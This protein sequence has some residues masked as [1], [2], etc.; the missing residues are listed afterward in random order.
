MQDAALPSAFRRLAGSNL[1]AQLAE[2][3]ALAAVPLAAVL[4]LG[5]EVGSTG[6]LA[7]AQTL[8]FLLLAIPFGLLA[9]RTDRR[10]LMAAAEWVRAAAL[11]AIP[12]AAAGGWLTLPLLGLLGCVAAVGTV[13]F[14]VT[15]PA[16]VPAL[17]PR[18]ALAAANG[19]LELARSLAYAGGPAVAGGLA[20]VAGAP[21]AFAAA[22][23]LSAM[24]ALLLAGLPEPAR[25][26]P[27]PARRPLAEVREGA[28]F[29][30]RH[31]WLRPIVA[32]AIVWNLAWFVL[33][34][35]FVPHAAATLGLDAAGIGLTLAAYGVGMV[36]GAVLAPPVVRALPIGRMIA[37]GPFVSVAAAAAMAAS[38]AWPEP[39]LAAAG[40]FLFGAG[41]ILWTIGQ[42]TLRQ[43][44]T[45]EGMLGRV[46]ALMTMATFGAR[47]LGGALGAAVGSA[48]GT[49]PCILLAAAGFVLQAAIIAGSAVPRV[50]ALP[51]SAAAAQPTS[52]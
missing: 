25:P 20:A 35:A 38:V 4:A 28:A 37:L 34:A 43:A 22:A 36:A 45:P 1:A 16:L 11:L 18:T 9:D 13:A 26:A 27:P 10:R 14:S 8:P 52:A 15:A 3:L 21:V 44:A 19:R 49:G 30:W 24:A 5:A 51:G 31:P 32:T 39:V 17:V 46:S 40:L 42:T 2:Q 48:W 6:L 50:R 47:P 33:Q 23:L 29:V 7:M 41:P 12:V